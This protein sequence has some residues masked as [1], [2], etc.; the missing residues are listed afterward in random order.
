M[1][2]SLLSTN[3]STT[4]VAKLLNDAQ[5]ISHQGDDTVYF[6]TRKSEISSN[7]IDLTCCN[8]RRR[9]HFGAP[10]LALRRMVEMVD[11]SDLCF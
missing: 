1:P 9:L 7:R 8:I 4:L 6:Q 2:Q 5:Q 10:H 11:V 3:I